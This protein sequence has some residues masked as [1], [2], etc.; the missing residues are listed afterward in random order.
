MEIIITRDS[1]MSYRKILIAFLKGI[2]FT[3]VLLVI[4]FGIK[5][6]FPYPH[7]SKWLQDS[8]T[9]ADTTFY[10][11]GTSR[12]QRSISP[13]ILKTHL[14]MYDFVNLGQASNSFLYSC[15]IASLLLQD[16]TKTKIIFIELSGL[17]ICPPDSYYLLMREADVWNVI[18]QHLSIQTTPADVGGLLSYTF[19]LRSDIKKIIYSKLNLYKNPE[20]GYLGAVREFKGPTTSVLTP[21][22]FTTR[23]NISPD[24]LNAY[25]HNI[26]QLQREA[27]RTGSQIIFI[28]PLT[29][30]KMDEFTVD[31][32]V[33]AQL[34]DNSKWSYSNEFMRTM[35]NQKFL[36]DEAHLNEIGASQYSYELLK[37]IEKRF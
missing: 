32:S 1:K 24:L 29:I 13:D 33:F 26:N 27:A 36:F 18:S 35:K 31:L 21:E 9:K 6:S 3:G 7:Q 22:S 17:A 2:L 16:T 34:P 8:K 4:S 37:V 14:P 19:S 12:V 23:T 28:L 30:D 5:L 11:I 10:F 15:R 25:L 20:L